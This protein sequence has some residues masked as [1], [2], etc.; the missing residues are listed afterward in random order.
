[1]T[2]DAAQLA[3]VKELLKR[4]ECRPLA[5][6]LAEFFPGPGISFLD[7]PD[8]LLG[9]CFRPDTEGGW[10]SAGEDA[11]LWQLVREASETGSSSQFE[12][13]LSGLLSGWESAAA[14]QEARESAGAAAPRFDEARITAMEGYPGWWRGYDSVEGAWKYIESSQRPSSQSSGW[15]V[16]TDA[17]R[18]SAADSIF[19]AAMAEL[20]ED[21]MEPTDRERQ[22]IYREIW[23]AVFAALAL[24]PRQSEAIRER[25]LQASRQGRSVP[26]T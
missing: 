13:W 10:L 24:T 18:E 6:R 8:S 25:A 12:A 4:E 17:M 7:E 20:R 22:E 26:L 9:Q 15:T 1:M 14:A 11:E 23:A 19:A 5:E 3:S 21:G 16:D 2:A